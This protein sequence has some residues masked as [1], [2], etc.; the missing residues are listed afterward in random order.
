MYKTPE[1]EMATI[2]NLMWFLAKTEGDADVLL[3]GAVYLADKYNSAIARKEWLEKSG[4][5]QVDGI[6]AEVKAL[7]ARKTA[8]AKRAER[9]AGYLQEALAGQKFETPKCSITYRNSTAVVIGDSATV[10]EYLESHGHTDCVTYA[11]PKIDK[12]ELKKLLNDGEVPGAS[13]EKR[14]NMQIK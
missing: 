11:E 8:I 14:Q 12:N 4:G 6:A 9:I 1:E 7:Q 5:C 3:D 13:L 2:R 10:V